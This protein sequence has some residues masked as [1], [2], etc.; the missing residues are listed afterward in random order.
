MCSFQFPGKAPVS[1]GQLVALTLPTI[2][3]GQES[4]LAVGYAE[5]SP[6]IC[7]VEQ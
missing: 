4:D 2:V 5:D 6:V 3:S 1:C 7:R